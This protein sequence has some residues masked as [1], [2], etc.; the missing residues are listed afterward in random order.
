MKNNQQANFKVW[1]DEENQTIREYMIGNQSEEDAKASVEELSRLEA[2]LKKKGIKELN[3]LFDA[4]RAGI[5]ASKA[6]RIYADWLKKGT[7]NKAA[8][9][10][11][12]VVQRTIANF[13]FSYTGK[14]EKMKYYS[15][16][17][18]ALKWLKE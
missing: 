12:G 16:E 15:N 13:I 9:Y 6:R 10:G 2:S 1:W 11:G 3:L 5:P 17:E 18:E 7:I 4:S 8:I 14:S